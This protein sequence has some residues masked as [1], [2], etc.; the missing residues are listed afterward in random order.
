VNYESGNEVIVKL[1][2]DNS[3][4]KQGIYIAALIN[5]II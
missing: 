2:L 5:N 1:V 3:I 4:R